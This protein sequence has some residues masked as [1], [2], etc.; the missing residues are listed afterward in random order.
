M[1][2]IIGSHYLLL[3]VGAAGI[4]IAALASV[5]IADALRKH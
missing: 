3:A 1:L 4:F 2:A 5:S